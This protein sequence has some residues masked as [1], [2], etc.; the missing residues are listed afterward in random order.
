[1]FC[2][3]REI[4]RKAVRLPVINDNSVDDSRVPVSLNVPGV[5]KAEM[6]KYSRVPGVPTA[7]MLDYSRVPGVPN[8][9]VG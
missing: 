7:E 3:F 8:A 4:S 2:L 6:T 1:M 5:P 9:E